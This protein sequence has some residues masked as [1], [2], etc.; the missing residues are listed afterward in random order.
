[1]TET[2]VNGYRRYNGFL[3]QV[4]HVAWSDMM[5]LKHNFWNTLVM[6]IMSPLLYLIAFG[7]GLR[8]GTTDIGVSYV[9]FVIPGIMSLSSLSSSFAS[10]STRLNVQRLYYKSFDEMVMCP[11]SMSAIVLGKSMLGLVR[12]MLGCFLM[13]ALG[14]F[15]APDLQLTPLAVICVIL[16][17]MVFSMLGVLAALLAKSHQS[18][19]TFNSLIILPMTFLCGTFFSVSSLDP[20]FQAVLYCLPLTHA[21][22]CIRAAC[23]PQVLEFPWWSLVVLVVFGIIVFL[24]CRHLLKTRKI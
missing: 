3:H 22:G 6:T 11:L 2:N 7:Y 13:Y 18:M 23:L 16:S 4:Y 15:L 9:A 8:T 1:M 14:L 24:I 20:I 21:S 10:T 5:F 12:G 17:C 19:A